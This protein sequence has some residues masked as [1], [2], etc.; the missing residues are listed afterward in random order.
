MKW[1]L[2]TNVVSETAK[3]APDR[4]L[5]AWMASRSPDQLA[6]SLVTLAELFAGV[7]QIENSQKRSAFLGWIETEVIKS[8]ENRVLPLTLE[9]LTD[10]LTLARQVQKRGASRNAPDLLIASTARVHNLILVSRNVKDF[11]RTGVVLYDPW[12]GKT[13]VMDAV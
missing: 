12:S 9:I 4:K 1:L 2:D 5:I 10:W 6:L 3:S 7:S 13:H 8:F 11:A